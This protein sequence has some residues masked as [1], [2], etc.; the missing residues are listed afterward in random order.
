MKVTRGAAMMTIGV[1][2]V[3]G[4]FCFALATRRPPSQERTDADDAGVRHTCRDGSIEY[5]AWRDLVRV[6]VIT[7][8]AGPM[9]EDFF[10]LLFAR[11]GHGCVVRNDQSQAVLPRLQALPGFDNTQLVRAFGSTDSARFLCWRA[12]DEPEVR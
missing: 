12:P 3:L 6:E 5:V 10:F 9:C 7:T 2:V 11:D 4:L 8:N 1:L